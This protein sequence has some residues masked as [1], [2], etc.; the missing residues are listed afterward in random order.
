MADTS[1]TGPAGDVAAGSTMFIS[2]FIEPGPISDQP[3]NHYSWLR[4]MAGLRS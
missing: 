2:R 1:A 4:S 3:H